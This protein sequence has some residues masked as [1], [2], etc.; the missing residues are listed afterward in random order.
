M[1]TDSLDNLLKKNV[2]MVTIL[3]KNILQNVWLGANVCY[4]VYMN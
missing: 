3:V 1:A 4:L 2:A